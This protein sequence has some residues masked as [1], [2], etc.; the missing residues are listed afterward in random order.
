MEK[1]TQSTFSEKAELKK[2]TIFDIHYLWT[3]FKLNKIWF[4]FS[5][6]ICVL[7]AFSYIYFSHPAYK[8]RGRML[9]VDKRTNSNVNAAL[10]LQNQMP[11]G[12]GSNITGNVG[13]ESEK[14]ILHSNII[15][16]DV[17]YSLGLHTEYRLQK[18]LKS[19]LLYK[20]QPINVEVSDKLLNYFDEELP[21]IK[22][23][24]NLKIIK[25][26]NG[27]EISGK[28]WANRKKTK[29]QKQFFEAL[30]AVIHTDVGDLRLV[31]NTSLKSN[32]KK[33]YSDKD[34][35]LRVDIIPP[36]TMARRFIKKMQLNS[37]SKKATY[38]VN[39]DLEDENMMRGIDFINYLIKF[40]NER[41]NDIKH[42]EVAL[43]DE[44]VN[45]RLERLDEELDSAD[46]RWELSKKHYQ[47]TE[48]KIDAEEVM[49]KKSAYES[50]LVN[51][52]IQQQLLDYLNEYIRDPSNRF[53]L[54]PV[55]VGV[56]SGDAVSMIGRHNQLVNDRK[57][58]L[59]SVSEQS[60]QVKQTTQ[61]IDELHPVIL[62][63][64]QRDRESLLLRKRVAEKEYNKYMGKVSSAP[65]QERVLTEISRSRNIKQGVYMTLLQKREE[66]ALELSTTIDKGRQIDETLFLKKTK[67]MKI[68]ALAFAI[69]FGIMIPYVILFLRRSLKK[70]I[71]TEVDLALLTRLPLIGNIPTNPRNDSE[72]FRTIRTNL[73]HM[74]KGNMKIVL[75]TSANE[76][77]GKT[78]FAVNVA[79][80]FAMI[81]EKTLLCDLNFRHPSVASELSINANGRLT[82]LLQNRILA[83]ETVL[84]AVE[85]TEVPSLDIL[86]AKV[87]GPSHPADLMAPKPLLF[88]MDCLREKYDIIVL[89]SSSIGKYSDVLID[90]LADLTCYVCCSGST[91]KASIEELQKM[92]S[93][94]RLPSPCIVM[95]H[96]N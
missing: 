69:V 42:K 27:Y 61:L 6:L 12:L 35:S 95:N 50:Q 20:T 18:I 54:I 28:M 22:H 46:T 66:N 63:A 37:A 74:L 23:R 9:I 7:L 91:P 31:E 45:K 1:K 92:K 41:T 90:G 53:E 94:F 70:N 25:D 88:L 8:V 81:G 14:E 39:L 64:I 40:Y 3:L 82:S 73:L 48:A 13:V 49:T 76:G 78:F 86:T 75:V 57:M 80:S 51:F 33:R 26:E 87:D 65:E 96:L 79:K 24:I 5:C 11:F 67:P 60:V 15:A 93:D 68:V 85:K 83:K 62:T 89:D 30:P 4:L 36:M 47:V 10:M 77:D 71:E 32:Y 16:K 43:N 21:L 56:Y 44:F 59:K 52:G 2:F 58:L 34:Y 84:D 19:Q 17:V 29:I 55:N 38:V 72:T